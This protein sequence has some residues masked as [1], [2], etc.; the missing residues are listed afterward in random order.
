MSESAVNIWIQA[1]ERAGLPELDFSVT[2]PWDDEG[3]VMNEI[4]YAHLMWARICV[5]SLTILSGSILRS[6]YAH[7]FEW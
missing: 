5:V 1:R 2:V 4:Q 3:N 6:N 7:A